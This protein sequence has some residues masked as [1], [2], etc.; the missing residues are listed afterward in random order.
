SFVKVNP[1]CHLNPVCIIQEIEFVKVQ[2]D[3]F[4]L[5]ISLFK[6]YRYNPFFKFLET[7]FNFVRCGIGS[8]KEL[9]KLLR[10]CRTAAPVTTVNYRTCYRLQV[11]A[12]MFLETF[13]LLGL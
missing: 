11:N 5:G 1:R 10:N 12:R 7:S 2:L 9:C 3:N 6:T 8:K 13:I 4:F